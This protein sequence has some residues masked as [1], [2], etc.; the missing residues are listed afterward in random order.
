LHREALTVVAGAAVLVVVWVCRNEARLGTFTVTT[1]AA[2]EIWRGNNQWARGSWPGDLDVQHEYLLARHREF[3]TLDEAGRARIYLVEAGHEA[4][5]HPGRL[6]WL[7]PRK[8]FL[9]F[10]ANFT[11]M[12]ID[13]VY[14]VLAPLALIGILAAW[15][16]SEQRPML[17]LLGVP[18]IAV[19]G[20]VLLTFG[21]P[22]F[23]HPVDPLIVLLGTIGIE[24]L[25]KVAA[26][27][28]RRPCLLR[29]MRSPAS[30]AKGTELR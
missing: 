3:D 25:A 16:N 26:R 22:R 6:L 29:L 20:V 2:E 10:T 24:R 5:N 23:R 8:T 28:S 15:S 12:G 4:I 14:V 1:Q 19:L 9:Y 21:H 27:A 11:L 30:Y 17:W 13:W 18:V 7:L